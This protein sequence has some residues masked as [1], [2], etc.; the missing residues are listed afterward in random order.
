MK[1][2]KLFCLISFVLLANVPY[3]A[4]IERTCDAYYVIE[5]SAAVYPS[6]APPALGPETI[7][8]QFGNFKAQGSCGATVPNRCRQRARDAAHQCMRTHWANPPDS[9]GWV[10]TDSAIRNYQITRPYLRGEIQNWICRT[11][12]VRNMTVRV[13]AVTTG[14]TDCPRTTLLQENFRVNCE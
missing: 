12:R 14:D 7:T 3:A 9:E 11:F 13:K 10:C 6:P 5:R 8:I 4:S 1:W 2:Y